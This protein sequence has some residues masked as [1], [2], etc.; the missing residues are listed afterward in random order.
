MKNT[1]LATLLVAVLG[2]C[3]SMSVEERLAQSQQSCQAYGFI[4]GTEGFAECMMLYDVYLQEREIRDRQAFA[5]AMR[6][7]SQDAQA[8][9]PVTCTTYGS[10]TGSQF[11]NFA[12]VSGQSSTT[13]R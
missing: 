5:A 3:A 8:R 2:G 1:V 7:M 4:P 12:N 10:A 13:C 9:R 11:G 6:Q